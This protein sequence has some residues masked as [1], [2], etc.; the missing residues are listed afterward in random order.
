MERAE[1]EWGKVERGRRVEDKGGPDWVA[2]DRRKTERLGACGEEFVP[3]GES[4]CCLADFG[5]EGFLIWAPSFSSRLA[6]LKFQHGW[7][8][9]GLVNKYG[10]DREEPPQ[11]FS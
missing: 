8:G 3:S 5:D 10:A 6:M 4:G 2:G 1:E 9:R 11:P 7:T